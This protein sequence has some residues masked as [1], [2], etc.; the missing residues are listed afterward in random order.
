MSNSDQPQQQQQRK[1][2]ALGNEEMDFIRGNSH[3]LTVEELAVSLN[4]TVDPI[5]R[6]IRE[7]NLISFSMDGDEQQRTLLRTRLYESKIWPE[8]QRQ[9]FDD[10]LEF[11]EDQWISSIQQFEQ[12]ASVLHTENMQVI[13]LVMKRIL[14]NRAM[15]QYKASVQ[16]AQAIE[17]DL[18]MELQLPQQERDKD[19]IRFLRDQLARRRSD[20]K[21][22]DRTIQEYQKAIDKLSQLLKATRDQRIQ[23]V[24]DSK[25]SWTAFQKLMQEEEHRRREGENIN[26]FDAAMYKEYQR[27]SQW[28]QYLD[29]ELDKPILTLE[30]INNEHEDGDQNGEDGDSAA[31]GSGATAAGAGDSVAAGDNGDSAS[32]SEGL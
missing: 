25:T 29:G 2:G 13:D 22:F 16:E 32:E 10:E 24:E 7:N 17:R 3:K 14:Q 31:A 9:L 4:R 8:V 21:D 11:F 6:Y 19:Q 26:I 1:R 5:K 27:L 30:V 18:E 15:A 20:Q 23:R 12:T 28:H